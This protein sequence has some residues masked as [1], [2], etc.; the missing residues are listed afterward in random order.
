M[1]YIIMISIFTGLLYSNNAV[2]QGVITAVEGDVS[3]HRCGDST[4]IKAEFFDN[5]FYGDTIKTTEGSLVTILHCDG[6][7][8][9]VE[10]GHMMVINSPADSINDEAKH[11]VHKTKVDPA[12]DFL[13][14]AETGSE[15][16]VPEIIEPAPEDSLEFTVYVPGNTALLVSMPKIVWSSY[17]GANW[18]SVTLK[19]NRKVVF[20]IATTDTLCEYVEQTDSLEPGP[21]VLR[22]KALSS[23]DTLKVTERT[24]TILSEDETTRVNQSIANI[25]GQN[26]DP[27]TR[28]LLNALIYQERMLR[29]EAI[30]A[31]QKLLDTHPDIPFL[32]KSLAQLY[33]ELGIPSISNHYLNK[34]E[35]MQLK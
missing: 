28:H 17:P 23:S 26:P 13:F 1:R 10:H 14:R 35:M 31:Y 18:Y 6:K 4:A 32:Y 33:R 21:Y 20:N 16:G 30:N 8:T 9:T 3:I 5:L 11:Y 34:Y 25:A 7:I 19:K 27:F 2:P 12:F 22:V 15:Q 29:L 24:I